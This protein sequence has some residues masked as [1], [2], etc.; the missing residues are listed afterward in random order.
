VEGPVPFL[1]VRLPEGGG[2]EQKDDR[3][4]AK[5]SSFEDVGRRGREFSWKLKY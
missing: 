1:K 5:H 3:E 2:R 4:D